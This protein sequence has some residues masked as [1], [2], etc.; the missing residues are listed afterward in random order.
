MKWLA[1][2]IAVAVAAIPIR[3]ACADDPPASEASKRCR[4]SYDATQGELGTTKLIEQSKRALACVVQCSKAVPE[5]EHWLTLESSCKRKLDD[6]KAR[7]PTLVFA[8][9]A[10]SGE[11]TTDVQ[12]SVDDTLAFDQLPNRPTQFDPGEYEFVFTHA[13]A[14][15]VAKTLVIRESENRTVRI[16]FGTSAADGSPGPTTPVTESSFWSPLRTTGLVTGLVGVAGIGVAAALGIS[17][18]SKNAESEQRC[19]TS[20]TPNRCDVQGVELRED[21]QRLGG[22]AT[23]SFIAGGVAVAGG[24]TMILLG[25]DDTEPA[26]SPATGRLRL[27]VAPAGVM[28]TGAW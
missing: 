24:V 6:L 19:D 16:E 20:V 1:M 14:S 15:P 26:A 7:I 12:I 22:L 13:D 27:G 11:E 23:A 4:A 28:L 8:A 18:N 21:A 10:P 2:P 25:D 5:G 3:F 17:A 9:V